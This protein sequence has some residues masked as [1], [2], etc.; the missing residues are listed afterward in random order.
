MRFAVMTSALITW[1]FFTLSQY[2]DPVLQPY[3]DDY[4]SLVKQSC[5]V[6][7]LNLPHSRL[8]RFLEPGRDRAAECGF[9]SRYWFIN[10]SPSYWNRIGEED[11]A[12]L[13]YHELSHC[14]LRMD[15]S[16]DPEN[17]M[18]YKTTPVTK[19][20]AQ[21]QVLQDAKDICHDQE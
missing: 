18:Y 12:Q 6:N 7:Q 3:V 11:R 17:Y 8:I 9:N 13:M 20:M 14:I 15:H 2:T 5:K 19:I 4:L 1:A 16:P 10:V 21:L